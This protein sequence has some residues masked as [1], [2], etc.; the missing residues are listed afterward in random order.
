MGCACDIPAFETRRVGRIDD[1][2]DMQDRIGAFAQFGEAY[3]II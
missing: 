1:A 2:C 3:G